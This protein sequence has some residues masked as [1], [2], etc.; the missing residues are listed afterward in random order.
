MVHLLIG[1]HVYAKRLYKSV[2]QYCFHS[3]RHVKAKRNHIKLFFPGKYVKFAMQIMPT[4]SYR[5]RLSLDSVQTSHTE[6]DKN[7]YK[8]M[9]RGPLATHIFITSAPKCSYKHNDE[10]SIKR[11]TCSSAGGVR[12]LLEKVRGQ[13]PGARRLIQN[14]I[15]QNHHYYLLLESTK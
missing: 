14:S 13:G 1:P 5:K 7:L 4:N 10:K 6:H 11:N 8:V 9:T 3:K 2:Q 12:S 15:L